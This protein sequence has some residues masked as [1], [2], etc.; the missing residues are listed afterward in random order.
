MYVIGNMIFLHIKEVYTTLVVL[1]IEVILYII[2]YMKI[3]LK[4]GLLKVTT[5]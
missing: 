5:Q 2:I 1:Y 3:K 4:Y